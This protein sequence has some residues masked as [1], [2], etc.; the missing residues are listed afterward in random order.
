MWG[1]GDEVVGACAQGVAMCGA[2]WVWSEGTYGE[3]YVAH[4]HAATPLGGATGNH[5]GGGG[6]AHVYIGGVYIGGVRGVWV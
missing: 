4:A 6:G 2:E 1:V 3:E 5:L